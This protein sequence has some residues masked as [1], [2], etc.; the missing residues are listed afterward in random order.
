MSHNL[1]G[2]GAGE[3]ESRGPVP[4]VCRISPS[5]ES[6]ITEY[7]VVYYRVYSQVPRV[8][9]IS[10]SIESC[11][12]EYTVYEDLTHNLWGAGAGE[13]EPG[14]PVPLVCRISPSIESYIT[15]YTI[16]FHASVVYHRVYGPAPRVCRISPSI[17]SYITEYTLAY[18][19]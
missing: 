14:G 5:I 11:I 8:F 18:N 9:R 2:A 13:A 17:E 10:P 12:T 1:C 19:S 15:E 3:A 7:R 6:Y 4:L 16:Q